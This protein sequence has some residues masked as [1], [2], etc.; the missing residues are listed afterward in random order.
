MPVEEVGAQLPGQL[1]R[2]HPDACEPH[3]CV[4][5]QVSGSHQLLRPGIEAVYAGLAIDCSVVAFKQVW[6]GAERLD[7]PRHSVAVFYPDG[8]VLL[9]PAFEVSTPEYFL[10]ELVSLDNIVRSD[11][12]GENLSLLDQSMPDIG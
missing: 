11:S 4:V 8:R 3:A 2:K 6:I 10:D 9:E 5:V 12:G 1:Q 7:L